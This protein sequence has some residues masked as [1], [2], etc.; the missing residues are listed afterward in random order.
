MNGPTCLV[1]GGYGYPCDE[2]KCGTVKTCIFVLKKI[3]CH[4]D[5]NL[6]K[7]ELKLQLLSYKG[8]VGE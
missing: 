2:M 5:A 7:K 6:F 1:C 3:G 4:A 8:R